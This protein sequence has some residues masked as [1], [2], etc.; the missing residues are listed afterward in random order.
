MT[1]AAVVAQERAVLTF[2]CNRCPSWFTQLTTFVIH[3][4]AMHGRP[5][6]ETP[7]EITTMFGH[8]SKAPIVC[9]RWGDRMPY[10]MD[11]AKAR[12]IALML[13][14]AAE[15]AEQDGFLYDFAR[16]NLKADERI[17]AEIMNEFRNWRDKRRTT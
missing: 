10:Q 13:L 2:R 9:L 7:I 5:V 1:G 6:T 14:E 15:S 12:E 11:T 4:R 3:I 8:K 16:E 17:G